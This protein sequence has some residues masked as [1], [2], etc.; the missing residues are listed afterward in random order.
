MLKG[1]GNCNEN[2]PCPYYAPCPAHEAARILTRE[3]WELVAFYRQCADQVTVV[4]ETVVPRLEGFEAAA[5]LYMHPE[6]LRPWLTEGACLLF[7]LLND[8]ETINWWEELGKPFHL[9]KPEDVRCPR[10]QKS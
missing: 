7:R 2:S 10:A 5:R 3:D 4:G 1:K 9:V 6:E 8:L